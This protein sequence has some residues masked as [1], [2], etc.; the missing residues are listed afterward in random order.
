MWWQKYYSHRITYLQTKRS[1]PPKTNP[2]ESRDTALRDNVHNIRWKK[3]F[4]RN[5][6]QLSNLDHVTTDRE[7]DETRWS[8]ESMLILDHVYLGC[9][10]RECKPNEGLIDEYRKIIDGRI[11]GGASEKLPE[12]ENMVQTLWRGRMT[13]KDIQINAL[14]DIANWQTKTIE[15]L[16]KDPTSCLHDHQFKKEELETVGGLSKVYSQIVLK[17]MYLESIG[18]LDILWSVNKL[19]RVVTKWTSAR[20]EQR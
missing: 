7:I 13:W 1:L 14:N 18:G 5:V 10:Q 11:S 15:Q 12:L 6:N 19:T 8:G 17:C 20:D 16:F 3:E 4:D 2:E 9:T